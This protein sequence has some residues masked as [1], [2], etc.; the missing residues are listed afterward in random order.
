MPLALD[1]DHIGTACMW[2]KVTMKEHATPG[3]KCMLCVAYTLV[4]GMLYGT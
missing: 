1:S 3:M 2:Q 4:I